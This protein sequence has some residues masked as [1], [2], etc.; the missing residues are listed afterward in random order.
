MNQSQVSFNCLRSV[1]SLSYTEIG[2]QAHD[3]TYRHHSPS[4]INLLCLFYC[5]YGVA[6]QSNHK[7]YILTYIIYFSSALSFI[8]WFNNTDLLF[9]FFRNLCGSQLDWW[10]ENIILMYLLWLRMY[11]S[12]RLL[13][14]LS[15]VRVTTYTLLIH[16]AD[17]N[18]TCLYFSLFYQLCSYCNPPIWKWNVSK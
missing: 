8:L 1:W 18:G 15:K 10:P 4:S 6:F 16:V 7:C 9:N 13:P 12:K 5:I 11:N 3:Q 14:Y 2:D 17:L